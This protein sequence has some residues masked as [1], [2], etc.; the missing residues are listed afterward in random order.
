[1]EDNSSVVLV[2]DN[3]VRFWLNVKPRSSKEQLGLDAYGELRLHVHAPAADGK[4]NEACIDFLAR[5]LRV[6]RSN[7]GIVMGEKSRRKLIRILGGAEVAQ[8]LQSKVGG[9]L[10]IIRQEI[11]ADG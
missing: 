10:S 5:L 7:I 9:S 8:T 3:D 11:K 4:A 6:P 2:R 1:M